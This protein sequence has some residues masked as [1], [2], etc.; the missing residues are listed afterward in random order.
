MDMSDDDGVVSMSPL[1]SPRHGER[2]WQQ[3]LKQLPLGGNGGVPAPGDDTPFLGSET[4]TGVSTGTLR[5]R[6]GSPPRER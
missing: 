1:I 2:P 6:R 5:Q 4:S 3:L